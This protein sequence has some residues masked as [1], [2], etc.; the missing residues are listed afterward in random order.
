MRLSK[1]D[2][3]AFCLLLGLTPKL[4]IGGVVIVDL[5]Y[6][7]LNHPKEIARD[8]ALGITESTK[9]RIDDMQYKCQKIPKLLHDMGSVKVT[10]STNLIRCELI[11]GLY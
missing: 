4:S 1:V 2:K 6:T 8:A 11:Y 10:Y 7:G 5:N 9:N 3:W